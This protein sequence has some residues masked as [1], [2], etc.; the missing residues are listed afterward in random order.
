MSEITFREKKI[1]YDLGHQREQ[2]KHSHVCCKAVPWW[3]SPTDT[4]K[5]GLQI[6]RHYSLREKGMPLPGIGI[7]IAK[8]AWCRP[9]LQEDLGKKLHF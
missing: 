1:A 6:L 7:E 4:V 8:A 5:Q 2:P 3:H 9:G